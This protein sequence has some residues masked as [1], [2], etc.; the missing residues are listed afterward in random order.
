[1]KRNVIVL[2]LLL[3]LLVPA[4]T[5]SAAGLDRIIGEGEV[6]DEDINVY[7]NDLHVMA[8]GQVNGKVTVFNGDVI[9]DGIITGDL[10]VF[11]GDVSV[12][13]IVNGNLVIFRGD[14]VLTDEARV[15]GDCFV[16]GA[17][18]DESGAASCASVG[19]RFL[20]NMPIPPGIPGRP[21]IPSV[22]VP[23]RAVSPIGRFFTGLSEAVGRS[24]L[25]GILA[26]VITAVFPRHLQQ[27]GQT[28]RARPAASGAVGFLTAVAV[29]SLLVLMLVVLAITCI[30][31]LLFPAVFLLALVPIAAL[32]LGWVAVGERFGSW[33]VRMVKLAQ[34]SL[35]VTA[36]LGTAVLTLALGLLTL[37]PPFSIGGGFVVWLI[38]LMLASVGLG[39]AVL[40]RLGTQPYPP[41]SVLP[42]KVEGVLETLPR[43]EEEQ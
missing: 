1:M 20:E 18:S 11:D 35:V 21:E 37:V 10:T 14:L 39:A 12:N 27:V 31:L 38:G 33:L 24:L 42:G 36:A 4:M 3:L 6:V 28:V 32:L 40:T 19:T 7:R 2:I 26:L 30:G 16:G 15:E 34:R 5:A 17:I 23:R 9:V 43:S 13:G 22:E 8:G 29:P 41:A 25:M